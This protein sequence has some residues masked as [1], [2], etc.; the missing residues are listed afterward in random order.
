MSL[1]LSCTLSDPDHKTAADLRDR[2][3]GCRAWMLRQRTDA[4]YEEA[5]THY[6]L[7]EGVKLGCQ[8]VL[9]DQ[10]GVNCFDSYLA[11]GA[12]LEVCSE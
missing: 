7:L 1:L 11:V 9:S 5:K 8:N 3:P 6:W 10:L 12:C 4:H 2:P